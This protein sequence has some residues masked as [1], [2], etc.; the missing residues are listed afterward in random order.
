MTNPRF[1]I[2]NIGC[3]GHVKKKFFGDMRSCRICAHFRQSI[4]TLSV[5]TQ[6]HFSKMD[7]KKKAALLD[8]D[9]DDGEMQTSVKTVAKRPQSSEKQSQ[10][11]K[12]KPAVTFSAED[13]SVDSEDV[14][15]E[16]GTEISFLGN[17]YFLTEKLSKKAELDGEIV[18]RSKDGKLKHVPYYI[19][20][21]KLNFGKRPQTAV[22]QKD[23]NEE[24]DEEDKPSSKAVQAPQ[25]RKRTVAK[26]E[27]TA[28]EALT[29]FMRIFGTLPK[30]AT[31]EVKF[32]F[33]SSECDE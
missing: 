29:E 2:D 5:L 22:S 1:Q 9:D 4:N 10:N 27:Q 20:N 12:P 33:G 17:T 19:M 7:L 28:R 14:Y 13:E 8:S 31:C 11:K 23:E 24:S 15:L 21:E 18:V 32:T 6:A 3:H 16:N 25:R 30:N 26:P